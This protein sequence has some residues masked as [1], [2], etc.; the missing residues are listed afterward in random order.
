MVLLFPTAFGKILLGIKAALL[1]WDTVVSL[2]SWNNIVA[3]LCNPGMDDCP[4]RGE[5]TQICLQKTGENMKFSIFSIF[6]DYYSMKSLEYFELLIVLRR[7]LAS[8]SKILL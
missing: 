2:F 6:C 3:G 4:L 5:N 7:F 8:K 1:R